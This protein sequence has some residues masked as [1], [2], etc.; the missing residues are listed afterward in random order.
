MRTE[1][2]SPLAT[3]FA[4]LKGATDR[5]R[6]WF[7]DQG[8][9]ARVALLVA[10]L[11]ALGVAGY[12]GSGDAPVDRAPAWLYEG[13]KLSSGDLD[14]IIDAL[15]LEGI[16]RI[17]DRASGKIGVK[18]ES[19]KAALDAIAKHKAVPRTLDDLGGDDE[20][21]SPWMLPAERE[22]RDNA[23]LQLS[24]QREIEEI[25]PAIT[26]AHVQIHR[27]KGRGFQG[28]PRISAFVRLRVEGRLSHK[29][30]L[31]IETFLTGN[32]PDLKPEAITVADQ[33]G[34]RYLAAGDSS[35]T[36][37]NRAHKKEED[38]QDKIREGLR[39]IPGVVVKVL[40]QQVA[41]TAPPPLAVARVEPSRPTPVNLVVPN[42]RAVVDP[43]PST[44]P[45]LPV[46]SPPPAL[47]RAMANVVVQVPRSFYLLEWQTKWP[48][49]LPTADDLQPMVATTRGIVE[50]AVRI[51]IP[52]DTLGEI[53]VDNI[54]DDVFAS[55]T[56]PA[57]ESR[58]V[59]LW[60]ALACGLGLTLA[61]TLATV[62]VRRVNRRP[63]ARPSASDWR[64][65]LVDDGPRGPSP[66]ASE[67]VRELIRLNPE[68][69]AGVLQRWIGQG[70]SIG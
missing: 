23:R 16:V 15:D 61:A 3:A 31:G 41:P 49:R 19:R 55:R 20:A 7:A 14:R 51:S 43:D 27:E 21:E 65:G 67:R 46:A 28:P 10:V 17:P 58:R 22:K 48:S 42:G 45:A 13:R 60:P 44:L 38:W 50:D 4:R 25:D 66:G 32:L 2:P 29:V 69:A 62:A 11:A 40:L 63:S 18:P 34:N 12:L 5:A 36:E 56:L 33:S 8:A 1:P 53:K 64:D 6:R 47:P 57:P 54:Q 37:Q 30:I 9:P 52:A 68:A 24:L 70:G 39:H 26:S 59:W 35:L